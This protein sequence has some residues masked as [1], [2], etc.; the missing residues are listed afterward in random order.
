[1]HCAIDHL[2]LT[3]SSTHGHLGCFYLLSTMN[4]ASMN[5]CGQVLSGR[6][7]ISTGVHIKGGEFL[8]CVLTVMFDHLRN[9]SKAAAPFCIPIRSA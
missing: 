5:I 7:F 8:G 1:M 6:I 3:H 9:C 4:N 2:L